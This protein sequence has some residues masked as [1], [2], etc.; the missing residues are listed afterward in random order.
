MVY[1]ITSPDQLNRIV[2]HIGSLKSKQPT[3]P[4]WD[5]KTP[6]FL[7]SLIFENLDLI[8]DKESDFAIQK[9]RRLTDSM[10]DDAISQ[11]CAKEDAEINN[12][13]QL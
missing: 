3:C 1:E 10:F 4:D 7:N 9:L 6:G 5:I 2:E 11:L 12:S 13:D 8:N